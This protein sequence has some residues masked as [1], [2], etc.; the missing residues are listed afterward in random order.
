MQEDYE[1]DEYLVAR[2]NDA[3]AL[4]EVN[5]LKS[6]CSAKSRIYAFFGILSPAMAMGH[7]CETLSPC[8]N[9]A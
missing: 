6:N 2:K 8:Q 1:V 3:M 5:R 9:Y 7:A 4:K